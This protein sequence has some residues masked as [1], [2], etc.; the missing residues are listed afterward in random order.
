MSEKKI[1]TVRAWVYAALA[2][3]AAVLM[4]IIGDSVVR[5]VALAVA[6]VYCLVMAWVNYRKAKN[7][8]E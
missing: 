7:E 8:E 6:A 2:V 4:P 5:L 3:V 1:R